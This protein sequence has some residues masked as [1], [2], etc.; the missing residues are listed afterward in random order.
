MIALVLALY[1]EGRT[2]ERFLPVVIRRT[3]EHILAQHGRIDVDVLEPIIVN[4]NIDRKFST[5]AE[6]IL[7]AAHRAHG[8]HA[9]IVHADADHPT[10]ER[11]LKE[12]FMPGHDLVQKAKDRVCNRLLPIIPVR[13]TEAWMLVDSEALRKV[14][15]TNIDEQALGLPTRARQIESDP[16]PK[17]TLHQILQNALAHYPRRRRGIVLGTIYEPLA[18]QLSL[19]RLSALPAYQQF[20]KDMTETLI[21]LHFAQ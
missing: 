12:R 14:I 16:D 8:F 7:E 6:R 4:H 13:M 15:R 3:V 19:E 5:R 20:V 18:R 9:L 17:Q 10:P 2:D 11:A 1:A 21:I